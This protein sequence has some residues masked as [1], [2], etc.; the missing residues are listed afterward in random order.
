MPIDREAVLAALKDIADP[1]SDADIV[2]AGIVRA[3]NVDNGDVRF[4]MEIAGSQAA[5]YEAA[6]AKVE[7]RLGE[8]DGIGTI[9]IVWV[10]GALVPPSLSVAVTVTVTAPKFSNSCETWNDAGPVSIS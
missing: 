3:L 6:K 9:S 10:T 2:S 4:V 8:L 7:A 5:E 1:A